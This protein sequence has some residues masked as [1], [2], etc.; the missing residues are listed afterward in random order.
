MNG[1][2]TLVAMIDVPSGSFSISGW[3]TSVNSWFEK[4][5]SGTNAI[6]D[7][8]HGVQQA[9]PQ[10]EQVRDQRAFGQRLRLTPA[11]T[12]R[13][14][15]GVSV[16]GSAGGGASV[17]AGAGGGAWI[18]DAGCGRV[19]RR[20]VSVLASCS[21]WV[22]SWRAMPRALPAQR[23]RSAASFGSR[24][25]P[26]H[27][28]RDAEDQHDLGEA[29]LEH[30]GQAFGLLSDLAASARSLKSASLPVRSLSC[31]VASSSPFVDGLLEAAHGGAEVGADAAQPLGAEQHQCN[32]EDDQEF[33]K[34]DSH[35]C[36][37]RGQP[38]A[39]GNDTRIRLRVRL[40][41]RGAQ[42]ERDRTV[43][44]E[45][46]LHVRAEPAERHT[47]GELPSRGRARRA[48][49]AADRVPAPPRP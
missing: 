21:S 6:A 16:G 35:C 20:V 5:A 18:V 42:P 33:A 47:F 12:H 44:G 48:R 37:R 19:A 29:D 24:C 49:T 11:W 9:R 40:R 23:P 30:A 8:D 39:D 28:Q 15:S 4:N 2:T 38:E 34:T 13:V 14:A 17:A 26:E 45:R 1:A 41:R 27:Q 22:L 36:L 7:R 46:N 43:V 32:H 31:W 3:A 25:W 10:L